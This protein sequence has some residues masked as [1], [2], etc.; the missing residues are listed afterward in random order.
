MNSLK[1]GPGQEPKEYPHLGSS[2]GGVVVEMRDEEDKER[3]ED[4]NLPYD[5]PGK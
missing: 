5:G 3:A 4:R 2:W 1:V